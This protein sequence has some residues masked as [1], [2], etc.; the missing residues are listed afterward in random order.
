MRTSKVR[1]AAADVVKIFGNH[2]ASLIRETYNALNAYL[3]DLS[4]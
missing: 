3:V 4:R 1:T 2:E